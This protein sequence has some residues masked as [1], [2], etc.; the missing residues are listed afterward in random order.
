M[1]KVPTVGPTEVED[2]TAREP[3]LEKTVMISEIL[4][5]PSEAELPKV[6]K[7]LATTTK[8][9]RLA[10]VLDAVMETTKTLTPCSY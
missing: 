4:S 2:D 9:R 1:P 10:S 7:A 6:P 5:P 3:D 8:K